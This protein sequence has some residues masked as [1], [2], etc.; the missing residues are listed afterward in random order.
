M[1]SI[2]PALAAGAW[3]TDHAR[4]V[5][6]FRGDLYLIDGATGAARRLTETNSAESVPRFSSDAKRVIFVRDGNGFSM[7]LATGFTR[8]LT[9]I[10]PAGTAGNAA[11][12]ATPQRGALAADQ[13]RL[14]EVI[15]DQMR[16]DSMR[17]ADAREPSG[18]KS[19]TLNAGE[20]VSNVSVSPSGTAVL[21][22]RKST[23]LNSSHT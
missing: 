3:S 5:V 15:R 22:D 12:P 6:E 13:R 21:L 10:R 2:G 7:E 11:A 20:R 23:R 8:Q 16:A 18:P 9:D 17:R 4:R 19:I 14:F 1:D